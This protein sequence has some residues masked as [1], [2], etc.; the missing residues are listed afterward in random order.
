MEWLG[1]AGLIAL[2][3]FLGG[4]AMFVRAD[5]IIKDKQATIDYLNDS[6]RMVTSWHTPVRKEGNVVPFRKTF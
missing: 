5:R 6:L 3:A 2:G 4:L 1:V